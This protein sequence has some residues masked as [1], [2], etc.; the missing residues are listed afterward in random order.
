MCLFTIYILLSIRLCE[1]RKVYVETDTESEQV[2][3]ELS[4]L[5]LQQL[6][7]LVTVMLTDI[8]YVIRQLL[9]TKII[10]YCAFYF[11]F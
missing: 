2:P 10:K 1:L 8:K 7:D 11:V 4:T 6:Q 9:F 5:P 3:F